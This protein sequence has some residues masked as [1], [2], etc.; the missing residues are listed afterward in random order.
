[1]KPDIG[2]ESRFLPTPLAFDAL[3]GGVIVGIFQERLVWRLEWCGYP[4]V[5]NFKDML[6]RIDTNTNVTD[7]RTDTA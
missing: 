6:I 5:K 4:T 3:I 1:M 7:G 2:Q